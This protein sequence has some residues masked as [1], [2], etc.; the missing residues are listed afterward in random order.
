[1]FNSAERTLFKTLI[2]IEV[3][4]VRTN[5]WVWYGLQCLFRMDLALLYT[6][7]K[8]LFHHHFNISFQHIEA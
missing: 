2:E 4:F 5:H 6:T 8:L 1:M 3:W 7:V